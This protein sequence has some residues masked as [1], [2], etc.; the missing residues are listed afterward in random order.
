MKNPWI[1][2]HELRNDVKLNR[3][4]QFAIKLAEYLEY[5]S[6]KDMLEEMPTEFGKWW[7]LHKLNPI[8]DD[9]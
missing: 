2:R 3:Q 4:Y 8:W 1:I 5:Q 6:V 7:N 9:E